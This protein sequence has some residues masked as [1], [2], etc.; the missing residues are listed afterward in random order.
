MA[1][2]TP[3]LSPAEKLDRLRLIRS[4]NVG[5]ITFHRLLERFG[6]AGA[7][8][9]ALPDLALRGGREG[10]IRICPKATAERE[11]DA[12]EA[13]GARLIARGEAGYPPLL[14]HIEDAPPL[15]TVLG[16]PHLLE[17]TAV[18]V[19][20]AR[21][22]SL[23]GQ[24]LARQIAAGIGKTGR[25]VVSGLAR[26]VDAAA[27]QGALETGTVAAVAGGVDVIYPKEN[28]RLY[29]NIVERGA[30]FSETEPGTQP[31]ARH[32]PRR[33]RLISGV[34]RGVVVIE[35]SL[36]SGSLISARMAL[37][38]GREVFAVPGS[39]LDPRARGANKLIRDGAILTESADDVARVLDE[40]LSSLI[41]EPESFDYG[42]PPPVLPAPAEVDRLRSDIT[43]KLGSA[44]VAVD[45]VI[46]ACQ[47]SPAVVSMVLL[48]L[49]LAGRLERH[50]G[51]RVSL[52]AGV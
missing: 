45:E 7:A 5:P 6:S 47:T 40:M 52:V 43:E 23:N 10:R 1:T 37:E 39:P 2:K 51:G 19:V 35:A 26:G 17:K 16:H 36:R 30:V 29:N 15:I 25:L 14:A 32:F 38:Q 24:H 13:I 50:P 21:N 27:H 20:G 33:N 18:G 28:T 44:P 41:A 34:S 49:E 12:V 22:A 3:S 9:E 46:R 42:A 4:E 11:M 48:E 8:L 31:Q